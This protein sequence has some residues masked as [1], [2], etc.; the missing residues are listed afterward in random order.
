[1]DKITDSA[2]PKT[3]KD[4]QTNLGASAS[5]QAGGKD[6]VTVSAQPSAGTASQVSIGSEGDA[7]V[8]VLPDGSTQVS[9]TPD[10]GRQ[11]NINLAAGIQ[12]RVSSEDLS[13]PRP[14]RNPQLNTDV[15]KVEVRPNTAATIANKTDTKLSADATPSN[16]ANAEVKTAAAPLVE[17]TA[18]GK[19]DES[20]VAVVEPKIET[21]A[22]DKSKLSNGMTPLTPLASGAEGPAPHGPGASQRAL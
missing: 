6:N 14:L 4:T 13:G 19:T 8:T 20:V 10:N 5:V 17:V 2:Q 15:A 22:A 9:L 16:E 21:K 18:G 3:E 12:V 1:K 11:F 7:K